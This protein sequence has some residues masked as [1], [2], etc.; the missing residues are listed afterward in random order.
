MRQ[1]TLR[2]LAEEA[3]TEVYDLFCGGGGFSAGARAAGARIAFACDNDAAALRWHRANHP[4]TEHLLA[5]LPAELPFPKDGRAFHVH[6]SPPCTRYSSCCT[7]VLTEE[8]K[9]QRASLVE[10]YLETAL[11][12]GAST[13]SMEQVHTG[14]IVQLVEAAAKRHPGR[15]AYGVF[16]F[17]E[18]GVPQKRKRLIAGSPHLVARL[19]RA[20]EEQPRVSVRQA[21]P[22]LRGPF[23][24]N[25]KYWVKSRKRMN[26]RAGQSIYVQAK[27]KLT[28]NCYH[29]DGPCPTLLAGRAFCWVTPT[30]PPTHAWLTTAE[31][32]R[33]QTF[34][35]AYC[36]PESGTAALRLIGN[37]VP[38]LVAELLMRRA[39][40]HSAWAGA[41]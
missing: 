13:W 20:R 36:W 30:D 14:N 26:R 27:A 19:S 37:S 1:L 32:A 25:S 22:E 24:R 12:C 28:D 31:Y 7:L 5:E 23:I 3:P 4:E 15:V 39:G 2:A 6:G 38:P 29:V 10:W 40:S 16:H 17:E 11:T 33:I 18:L 41:A 34:P 8:Q 35:A 21:L 9:R